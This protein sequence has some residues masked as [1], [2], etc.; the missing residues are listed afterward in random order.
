MADE[1]FFCVHIKERSRNNIT[2]GCNGILDLY[3][4]LAVW[5]CITISID[6]SAGYCVRFPSLRGTVTPLTRCARILISPTRY[7]GLTVHTVVSIRQMAP[8][9]SSRIISTR[10]INL[11]PNI[12]VKCEPM[13][14]RF[15]TEQYFGEVW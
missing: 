9:T 3:S 6:F 2:M 5:G 13:V 15:F 14:C 11:G 7:S 1:I 10:N 8:M 4:L 12:A